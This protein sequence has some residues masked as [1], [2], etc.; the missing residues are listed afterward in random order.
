MREPDTYGWALARCSN[1]D[2][3]GCPWDGAPG[4]PEVLARASIIKENFLPTS[5]NTR[6]LMRGGGKSLRDSFWPMM[7]GNATDHIQAETL[8]GILGFWLYF[9]LHQDNYQEGGRS[10]CLGPRIRTR[11]PAAV[12]WLTLNMR[13]VLSLRLCSL[14]CTSGRTDGRTEGQRHF[15][16]S[17]CDSP[18]FVVPP[19]TSKRFTG[20]KH[21]GHADSSPKLYQW[22]NS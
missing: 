21:A 1:H 8:R 3:W 13:P 14:M 10:F 11:R 4:M 12:P 5:R 22:Q 15:S 17:S 2:D 7:V 6:H 9:S 16:E 20:E 19:S 18:L